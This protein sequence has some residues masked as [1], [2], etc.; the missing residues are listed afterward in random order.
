MDSL[1]KIRLYLRAGRV[2]TAGGGVCAAGQAGGPPDPTTSPQNAR[3]QPRHPRP[4]RAAASPRQ[5][6]TCAFLLSSQLLCSGH[7]FI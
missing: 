1:V 5:N 2:R 6:V 7:K 3:A 4:H